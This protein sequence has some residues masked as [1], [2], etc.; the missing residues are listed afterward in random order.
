M[1]A[2]VET[3]KIALP[4]SG[5]VRVLWAASVHIQ[6]LSLSGGG[7]VLDQSGIPTMFDSQKCRQTKVG[8]VL[9]AIKTRSFSTLKESSV[10][11]SFPAS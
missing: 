8:N 10:F 11:Q 6:F 9:L 3:A 4:P 2:M 5:P 7:F 1:P